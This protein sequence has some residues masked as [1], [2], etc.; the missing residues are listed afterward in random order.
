MLV[1]TKDGWF[2]EV[3]LS[4]TRIAKSVLLLFYHQLV[5]RN[6]VDGFWQVRGLLCD[7]IMLVEVYIVLSI[8]LVCYRVAWNLGVIL[9][10]RME[11]RWSS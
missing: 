7:A 6:G 4:T 2:A 8:C 3:D 1:V 9:R 11:Q 10:H 5:N